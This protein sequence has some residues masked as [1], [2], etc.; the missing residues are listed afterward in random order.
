M[1]DKMSSH[2][3]KARSALVNLRPLWRRRDGRSLTK[4]SSKV[5]IN[6]SHVWPLRALHKEIR[7]LNSVVSEVLVEYEQILSVNQ[8]LGLKHWIPRSNL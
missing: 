1:S 3:Q 6:G 2:I 7:C 4:I 8:I 5:P